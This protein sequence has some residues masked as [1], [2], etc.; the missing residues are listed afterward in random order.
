MVG[1]HSYRKSSKIT[2][3]AP[4]TPTRNR[5]PSAKARETMAATDEAGRT[6][7]TMENVPMSGMQY[8]KL[9][10]MLTSQIEYLAVKIDALKQEAA[11]EASI[12]KEGLAMEIGVLK[13]GFAKEISILKQGF[14]EEMEKLKR[15]I[16]GMVQTQLA[17]VQ[18]PSGTSPSYAAVA[19]TPPASNPSSPRLLNTGS[20]SPPPRNDTMYCTID[21]SR[22]AEENKGR[23]QPGA[24]RKALEEEMRTQTEQEKW[25]CIAITKDPRNTERI[26]VT[27]RDEQELNQVKEAAKKVAASGARVIRDQLYPVKVDNANSTAILNQNGTVR[28]G[29]AEIFGKENEVQIAKIAWL[30]NKNAAKAYGSMVVYVTKSSDATRLLHGRYF[31]VEGESAFTRIFEHRS[32]PVQCYNCQEIGHKAFSCKKAQR[33]A[34]CSKDGHRHSDCIETIPK[35]VPCGG[36]HESFSRNCPVLH[37]SR[38]SQNNLPPAVASLENTQ[39]LLDA[40]LLSST[41]MHNPTIW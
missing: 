40:Q 15:E 11:N 29:A 25:N 41:Q 24:F 33:C 27:C 14:A 4:T 1:Y 7:E 39:A 3:M 30:S 2:K 19:S 36:P 31:N 35:C 8:L 6:Q 13:E 12:L 32:G 26:R 34:K 18:V 9:V 16:A 17:N 37:P 5:I 10:G 38:S 22:V 21:T 20:P 23:A 28:E